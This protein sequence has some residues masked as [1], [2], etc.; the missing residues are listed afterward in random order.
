MIFC[1]LSLAAHLS[2]VLYL[3]SK[4]PS[5]YCLIAF[6][7]LKTASNSVH[8][9]LGRRNDLSLRSARQ[10]SA[11]ITFAIGSWHAHLQTRLDAQCC[12]TALDRLWSGR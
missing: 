7:K 2:S 1:A 9:H 10:Y 12:S 11:G 6:S 3:A 4:G 5:L 8:F